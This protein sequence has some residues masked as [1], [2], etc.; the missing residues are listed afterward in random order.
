MS[1]R[2]ESLKQ[3]L[4]S[5]LAHRSLSRKLLRGAGHVCR[6]VHPGA[7]CKAIGVVEGLLPGPEKPKGRPPAG[8]RETAG[9]PV[10]QSQ[11][12]N[13]RSAWDALRPVLTASAALSLTK[14]LVSMHRGV[15]TGKVLNSMSTI[16]RTT[17]PLNP[18]RAHGRKGGAFQTADLWDPYGSR[19][20]RL[21]S[22]LGGW[23]P[24]SMIGF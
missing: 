17:V 19:I 21:V 6:A 9:R 5:Q 23:T 11:P 2:T 8:S 15:K 7:A 14:A 10:R 1:Q 3:R 24:G 16:M 13:W 12:L 22:Q 20:D 18:G 4:K